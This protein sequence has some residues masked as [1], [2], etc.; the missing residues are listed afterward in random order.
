MTTTLEFDQATAKRMEAMYLGPDA[1][2]RRREVIALLAPRTGERVLDVG[3]GPGFLS[4]EIGAIVGPTGHVEGI[5]TSDAMLA[6]AR[7]RCA[8]QPW[9][10]IHR[11]DAAHVE[12]PDATFDAVVAVQ[13][14]E[15]VP[16]VAGSLAHLFRVLRPGGRVLIVATDWDS[17]VW[18][19]SDAQRMA[20]VLSAFEEHLFDPHL[21]RH[22]GPLLVSAGFWVER[23][24][25][26]VQ[27]NSTLGPD[28]FSHGL[29][30]LI[31]RFVPGRRGVTSDDADAW[32]EDLRE[33]G[34]HGKYF[35]SLN[36]YMFLASKP[37]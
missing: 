14:H 19:T 20:L 6:A 9:V 27:L 16:D 30:D 36:Q 22:L 4:A 18:G 5:D 7:A 10:A 31:R 1:V 34:R 3:C 33:R 37:A 35:F 11:G 32:A 15:Y 21:P 26:F 2:R 29:I 28:T 25:V 13:V 24:D 12:L 8:A 17:I 23:C